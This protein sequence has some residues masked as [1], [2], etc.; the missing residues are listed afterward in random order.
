MVDFEN[1]MD[2][3][4]ESLEELYR[5]LW[6]NSKGNYRIEAEVS[7][8]IAEINR[9]QSIKTNKDSRRWTKFSLVLSGLALAFACTSAIF[10]YIDW[11][12]DLEWQNKQIL[13]LDKI[14]R[15]NKEQKIDL[16]IKSK[17][18]KELSQDAIEFPIQ[19]DSVNTNK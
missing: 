15:I 19:I 6:I 10:S 13:K 8:L 2:L 7:L 4:E 16:E 18:S 12:G 11:K 17:Q 5:R 9:R 3:S 14:S 1:P